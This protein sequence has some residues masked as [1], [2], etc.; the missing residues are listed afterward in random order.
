MLKSTRE[1][2]I[3]TITLLILDGIYLY[4]TQKMFADQITNIQRVVMQFKPIGAIICYLLIV[5]GLN[6][7]I[8]QRNRS[9]TEAFILGIVIYGI[10]DSTNYATL[11]KWSAELA[12]MDTLWGGALFA[13][14]TY[15]T[16]M[17]A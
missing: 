5:S 17:L 7:F 12:I 3:S 10:Y 11:K 9:T 2:I 4:L 14:T 16:Y 6:Y 1:L 13:L 8:I 15:I